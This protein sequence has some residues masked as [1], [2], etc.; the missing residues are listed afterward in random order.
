MSGTRWA[1]SARGAA[2]R[3]TAESCS[4]SG[5]FF[6]LYINYYWSKMLLTVIKHV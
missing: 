3:I 6:S 1:C 2:A 5:D 4:T